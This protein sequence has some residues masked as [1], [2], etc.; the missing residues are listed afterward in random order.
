MVLD[1]TLR[2]K[3]DW[4][5]KIGKKFN[6]LNLSLIPMSLNFFN[7]FFSNVS[8]NNSKQNCIFANWL[9]NIS[10]L[11]QIVL[12][13]DDPSP[14]PSVIPPPE[15]QE[16]QRP[17]PSHS[18][19]PPLPPPPGAVNDTVDPVSA[20]DRNQFLETGQLSAELNKRRSVPGESR[21]SPVPGGPRVVP[22]TM[23]P[24]E[25]NGLRSETI[26]SEG[27]EVPAPRRTTGEGVVQPPPPV[28]MA[29][30]STMSA[31]PRTSAEGD[32]EAPQRTVPKK[33][34][35]PQPPRPTEGRTNAEGTNDESAGG[36]RAPVPNVP[37]TVMV[38]DSGSAF[39]NTDDRR[40]AEGEADPEGSDLEEGEISDLEIISG[41]EFEQEEEGAEEESPADKRKE[42]RQ[43][44]P[45]P[46]VS[47]HVDKQEKRR[48]SIYFLFNFITCRV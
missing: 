19:S 9:I 12:E 36:R 8:I 37:R 18:T 20:S 34:M 29:A 17:R 43:S 48:R 26:G 27:D 33:Q 5:K 30:A 25:P 31:E 4:S 46:S 28:M 44:S 6:K 35:M 21:Q 22:G 23:E 11:I 3:Y 45:A 24:D 15:N 2:R 38:G 41:G 39:N 40:G 13:Q 32:N 10:L 7:N 14:W 1:E 47:P 42:S 16:Q